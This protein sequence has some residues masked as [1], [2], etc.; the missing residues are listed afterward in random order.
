MPAKKHKCS[1]CG[2]SVCGE[3]GG[4]EGLGFR[5]LGLLAFRLPLLQAAL[6]RLGVELP[7]RNVQPELLS[8]GEGDPMSDHV[9]GEF[10]WS[11]TC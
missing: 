1:V 8:M 4:G 9:L 5:V 11:P 10:T 7:R 2:L 6:E 3:G